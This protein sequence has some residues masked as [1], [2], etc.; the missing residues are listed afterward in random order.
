MIDQQHIDSILEELINSHA[1][2]KGRINDLYADRRAF[3]AMF[4]AMAVAL[5]ARG[6]LSRDDLSVT[7]QHLTN[8]M[9]LDG[10]EPRSIELVKSF[11]AV[12]LQPFPN[13]R[14]DIKN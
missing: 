6:S 14:P 13:H 10:A 4:H 1:E 7:I 9:V 8:A 11:Q 12:L 3:F 2:M 5:E